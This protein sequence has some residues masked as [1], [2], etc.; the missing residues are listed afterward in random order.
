M[1]MLSSSDTAN[2]VALLVSRCASQRTQV[3]R[4]A[5]AHE[6]G[7]A[8]AFFHGRGGSASR[9]GGKTE[10]AVIAAPRGSV[11]GFL[12]VTEQGE[13]IHRK[14]GVRALAERNLEQIGRANV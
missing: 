7:I 2:D 8:I 10:R 11:N 9:G 12:R 5:V 3:A 4:T 6:S 1:V 14:Y 13:V